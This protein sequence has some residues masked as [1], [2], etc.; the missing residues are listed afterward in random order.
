M[1]AAIPLF[2]Y[3]TLQQ[4]SVQIG[5]Y[6]RLLEGSP[7]VLAGYRLE[8]ITIENPEVVGLSGMEVHRIAVPTGEAP[9]CIEGMLFRLTRDELAATDAY[10]GDNYERAEVTLASGRCAFVYI[11]PQRKG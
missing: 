11:A 5:T 9:D 8:S 7:D 1:G 2:S 10:E 3:G 4:G 6:G